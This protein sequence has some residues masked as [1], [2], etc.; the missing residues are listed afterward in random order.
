MLAFFS[1]AVFIHVS[2]L[3]F[4]ERRAVLSMQRLESPVISSGG[5]K[6][7]I[8]YAFY[9]KVMLVIGS[10][11]FTWSA[12]TQMGLPIIAEYFVKISG[13]VALTLVFALVWSK[14]KKRNALVLAEINK[15]NKRDKEQSG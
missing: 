14:D 4:Y 7:Y 9:M 3:K 10:Y 5:G 8:S 13:V 6:W 2:S 15:N 11:A 12:L 1:L